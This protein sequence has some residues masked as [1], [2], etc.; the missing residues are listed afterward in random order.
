MLR[1]SILLFAFCALPL[2][3]ETSAVNKLIQEFV[4]SFNAGDDAMQAFFQKHAAAD[5]PV[6]RRMGR[7]KQTKAQLGILTLGA[8][9]AE[10]A[11]SASAAMT[12]EKGK[13]LTMNFQ[14][15]PGAAPKLAAYAVKL[16]PPRPQA[17]T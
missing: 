9:T 4:R 3:A 8:I 7:Y 17:A 6:E 15:E 16:G 13:P 12:S 5:P 10:S 11:Q 1:L 2:P 14:F